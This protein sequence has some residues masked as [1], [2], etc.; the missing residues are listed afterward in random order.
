MT[1]RHSM[2]DL[3]RAAARPDYVTSEDV[4]QAAEGGET[5]P[6]DRRIGGYYDPDP[7]GTHEPPEPEEPPDMNTLLRRATGVLTDEERAELE[8]D[9]ANRRDEARGPVSGSADG[10][11]RGEDTKPRL[12]S[13]RVMNALLKD[14]VWSRRHGRSRATTVDELRYAMDDPDE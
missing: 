14:A 7:A 9:V 1:E 5:E 10:G 8:R 4:R 2:N 13:G 12:S 3:L 6:P 11:Q